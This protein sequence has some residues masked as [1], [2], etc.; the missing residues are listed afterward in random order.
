MAQTALTPAE[1]SARATARRAISGR[2]LARGT[3]WLWGGNIVGQAAWFGSL[4]VLGALLPPNAFGAVAIGIVIATAAALVQDAG[5][6]GTIVLKRELTAGD[7]ARV[8]SL[9]LAIGIAITIAA[10]TLA[11]PIVQ[12]FNPGGDVLVLKV[13]MLSVAIRALA[14][15]PMAILQRSLNFKLHASAQATSLLVAAAAAIVAALAGAGVWALVVRQLAAA[16]LLPLLAWIAAVRPMRAE[17]AAPP[18]ERGLTRRRGGF[19]FFLLATTSFVALSTDTVVVGHS[20]GAV[21]L[22]LYS[23]AFTLA[24]APLTTFAW[25]IGK[26]VFPA[27]AQTSDLDLIVERMLRITRLTATALL[28]LL[29]PTLLLAPVL[30]P[31]ILGDDWKP[32][33]VPFQILVCV[34]VGHAILVALGDSLS[35]VGVI[36]W[37]ALVEG[38]WALAMIAALIVLVHADGITGAALAH[39]LVFFPYAFVWLRFGTRRLGTSAGAMFGALREIA[40]AAIAQALVTYGCFTLLERVSASPLA[41]ASVAA[42]AGLV[43]LVVFVARFSPTLAGECRA[44]AVAVTGG[45][46]I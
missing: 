5:S 39:L 12:H 31:G 10:V 14:I 36:R 22:G 34:G 2:T 44:F 13:L 28:P 23:L 3:S 11:E 30:L 9:N 27:T 38:G 18:R 16:L 1:A 45:R 40:F 32:M 21:Q 33:V 19:W 8:V 4:I 15:A 29:P 20:G 41:A 43:A 17:F 35:G 46:A 24:F 7:V 42:A 25:Q 26:V 37:R 6:R